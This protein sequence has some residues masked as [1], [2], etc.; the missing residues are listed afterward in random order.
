[1]PCRTFLLGFRHAERQSPLPSL[2]GN[3]MSFWAEYFCQVFLTFVDPL[4]ISLNGKLLIHLDKLG[5]NY[6]REKFSSLSACS[7]RWLALWMFVVNST[8]EA[9]PAIS[10]YFREWEL[11]WSGLRLLWWVFNKCESLMKGKVIKIRCW[12]LSEIIF[13]N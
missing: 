10:S 7:T 6:C 8:Q 2:V 11:L 3:I 12:D 4:Q 13:F 1:M 9:F 5:A